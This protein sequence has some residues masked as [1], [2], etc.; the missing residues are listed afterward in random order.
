MRLLLVVLVF[1][2][3]GV[4]GAVGIMVWEPW[5]DGDNAAQKAVPAIPTT[6]ADV[7]RLT[8]HE[9][10]GLVASNCP[11]VISVRI[12]SNA[13]ASYSGNGKWQVRWREDYWTVDEVTG[14]VIP[15]GFNQWEVFCQ[16]ERN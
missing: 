9:A 6:M 3:V 2:A 1:I 4:S 13:I 12:G 8:S 11:N 5:G 16:R 10:V 14:T 7:P 15:L